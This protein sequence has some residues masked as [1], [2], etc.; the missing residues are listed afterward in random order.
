MRSLLNCP[1]EAGEVIK[2]RYTT[3]THYAVVSNRYGSDRMP[4]VI[5]NS[6]ERGGVTE[7]TWT[8]AV[9]SQQVE[10]SILDSGMNRLDVLAC[11]RSFL[12]EGGY[13][14]FGNNCENFVR[15]ILGVDP[16]SKQLIAASIAV[17]SVAYAAYKLSKGDIIVTLAA[18]LGTLIV[19]TKLAAD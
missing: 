19:T 1:F 7:R 9:A 12:G 5:D 3:F 2:I 10:K 18:A 15:K 17:P 6:L 4:M 8:E 14:L 16:S 13:S 11:A